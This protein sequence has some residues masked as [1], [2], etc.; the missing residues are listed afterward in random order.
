MSA[1]LNL[2]PLNFV[3]LVSLLGECTQKIP[4]I[5]IELLTDVNMILHY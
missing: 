1:N 3:T 4:K 2:N 5:E